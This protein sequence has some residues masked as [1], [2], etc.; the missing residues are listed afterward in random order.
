VTAEAPSDHP[1]DPGDGAEPCAGR[2]RAEAA[3]AAGPV[4][5]VPLERGTG[6]FVRIHGETFLGR[7]PEPRF[8]S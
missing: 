5:G 7:L 6:L 2:A 4:R 1:G 3:R 8:R